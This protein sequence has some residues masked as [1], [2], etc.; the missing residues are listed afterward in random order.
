MM[1]YQYVGV[2]SKISPTFGEM[3][4]GAKLLLGIVGPVWIS[5]TLEYSIQK[6]KSGSLRA[7]ESGL[8]SA[9][10]RGKPLLAQS[11]LR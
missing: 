4:A 1:D 2:A 11:P 5:C 7:L 3:L 9:G 8:K 6:S 10:S